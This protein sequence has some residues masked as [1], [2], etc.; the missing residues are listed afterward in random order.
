MDISTGI[1]IMKSL[2][3]ASRLKVINALQ[4]KPQY[5]EELANRLN[6]A[7]STVS[8]HLKKLEAVG[9]VTKTRE[10]YYITYHLND[11]LFSKT[12][13]ELTS[14]DNID[15]FIEEE[16]VKSYREKVLKTF[17]K[18]NKIQKLPVQHKKKII[19]LEE[20]LKKFEPGKKYK[21]EAVNE[22]IL[23]HYEDYCTVRRLF[24]EEGMMQR[25]NQV[26]WINKERII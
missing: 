6:L 15:N 8:F 9:L 16:R 4:S 5:V 26:Y 12:I 24:I 13:R 10:Q 7:V 18:R 11:E 20:L 2:S 14:F 23:N 22:I 1:E 3:D 21:E 17:F 25:E 19:I